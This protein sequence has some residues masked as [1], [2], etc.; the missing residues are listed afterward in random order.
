MSLLQ[1]FERWEQHGNA[2]KCFYCGVETLYG[3]NTPE[4]HPYFRTKDHFIAKSRRRLWLS[5]VPPALATLTGKVYACCACNGT[6]GN[7]PPEALREHVRILTG[8]DT[9]YAEKML[10]MDLR[11]EE[12]YLRF[13]EAAFEQTK[14]DNA[15]EVRKS[16][17]IT[18]ARRAAGLLPTA[19][20]KSIR[21]KAMK[22]NVWW[23]AMNSLGRLIYTFRQHGLNPDVVEALHG[24]ITLIKGTLPEEF[25]RKNLCGGGI[26]NVK[27]D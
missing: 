9:F 23:D 16:V 24:T 18:E 10:S 5:M 7:R 13:C 26:V 11:D 4:S 1:F 8:N 27:K 25:A 22:E 2:T 12:E 20:H 17:A 14:I 3:P 6:K 19:K 15:E 21:R